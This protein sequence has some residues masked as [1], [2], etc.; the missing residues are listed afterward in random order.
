MLAADQPGM[1][2]V[3]R[4]SYSLYLWHWPVIV[5]LPTVMAGQDAYFD[6]A[7]ILLPAR[8]SPS[9]LSTSSRIRCGA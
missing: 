3:G 6:A 2:Y 5:F 8:P 4:V 7:A 9:F 1:R